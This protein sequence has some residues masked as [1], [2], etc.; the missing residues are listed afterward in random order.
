MI[1]AYDASY[2]V[3]AEKVLGWMLD[4]AVNLFAVEAPKFWRLFLSGG[5]A[6][7]FGCGESRLLSG[8]TG[9]ELAVEV[10]AGAKV[11]FRR[12]PPREV[13]GLS[14]EYWAGWALARYQW[15][16]ALSFAEIDEIVPIASVIAMY[17][18]FHEMDIR[19]FFDAMNR[20][21]LSARPDTNLKR[22]SVAAGFS[23]DDLARLS[24]VPVRMIQHY[25]QRVKN[26]NRAAY[27]T[28]AQLAQALRC[29]PESLAERVLPGDDWD[30]VGGRRK[31]WGS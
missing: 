16:T 9:Y 20:I 28:V 27:E 19:Q 17:N 4:T 5:Y 3:H 21:V 23:Q 8:M 10:L 26:I 22:L 2:L 15:Y 11:R 31:V 29:R 30:G 25:E 7:R 12:N 6:E 1:H 14:P 24:G 13:N 18:P